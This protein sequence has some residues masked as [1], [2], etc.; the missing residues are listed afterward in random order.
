MRNTKVIL[1]KGIRMDKDYKNVIRYGENEALQLV[2]TNMVVERDDCSFLRTDEPIRINVDYGTCLQA[3]YIAFQN[4][5]YSGKWFFAWI[6]EV[7]YGGENRTDIIYTIDVWTTWY[8]YWT[9]NTKVFVKRQHVDDDTVGINTQPEE[10]ANN[11]GQ[12]ICDNERTLDIIGAESFFWFVIASNFEPQNDTRYAGVGAYGGYPQGSQW[13]AWLVNINSMST[14]INDISD[15]VFDVTVS[16]H[17]AD[18]Q[19]MFALPYQAFNLIGDVDETT[20]KVRV[21]AGNKLD[22]LLTYSKTQFRQ[23]DNFTPKNNKCYTH[24]FSFARITNNSGIV[25]DYKIEDFNEVDE[26]GNITDNMTFNAIGIPC[27]GYAG[28]IRPKFYQGLENNEDEAI[29]IGKYPT[30]SWS[31]DGYTNW[32]TQNAVNMAF[33]GLNMGLGFLTGSVPNS[34]GRVDMTGALTGGISTAES[35]LTGII[36]ASFLPNTAQGNANQ[37]DLNFVFNLNRFKIMHMR[38]KLE[39]ISRIDNYFTRFGYAI[40]DTVTPLLNSRTHWN[41]LEIGEFEEIGEPNNYNNI[42]INSKDMDQ[43]NQICRN[44]VTIWH[45]HNEIGNFNLENNIRQ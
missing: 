8:E 28:K 26:D 43:I 12:I 38:P 33:S 21:G 15:W 7:R 29:S 36:N 42:S 39:Y 45:N 5:D 44:G 35:V 41:Y 40:N 30:L 14:A 37:G 22:D 17:A 31:S 25:N 23:F 3:N 4:P 10:I 19:T 1:A 6:D 9:K 13:F 18:I 20:H 27:E 34:Q 24:P 32:L 2:R 16:G 11:I